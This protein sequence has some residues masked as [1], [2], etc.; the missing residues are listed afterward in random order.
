MSIHDLPKSELINQLIFLH[1]P[2]T[3]HWRI[4]RHELFFVITRLI[5]LRRTCPRGLAGAIIV[6][7]NRIVSIGYPGSPPGAVHCFDV[8]CKIGATCGC[9]RT[10]HAELNAI[11]WAARAGVSIDKASIYTSISP[12]PQ[13]AKAIVASGISACYFIEA[14]RILDGIEYLL[15]NGVKVFQ[16]CNRSYHEG[17]P[18]SS[19]SPVLS[20]GHV[21]NYE[22]EVS[23]GTPEE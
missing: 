11:S 22:E 1:P 2:K 19:I 16:Y 13:C 15:S 18:T 9:E 12:C 7:D 8:G 23:N 17:S 20:V 10:Q 4:D 21:I 6:R 5:A 3:A 14:Y